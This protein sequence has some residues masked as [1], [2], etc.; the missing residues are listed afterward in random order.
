MYFIQLADE[1]RGVIQKTI[2]IKGIK[3]EMESEF[4]L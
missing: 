2:N 4:F 3:K 1:I